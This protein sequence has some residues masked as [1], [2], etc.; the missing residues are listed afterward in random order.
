MSE[1]PMWEIFCTIERFRTDKKDPLFNI[2]CRIRATSMFY[3]GPNPEPAQWW[4][5]IDPPEDYDEEEGYSYTEQEVEII[6]ELVEILRKEHAWRGLEFEGWTEG[7]ENYHL[8]LPN[9]KCNLVS[10]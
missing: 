8:I 6:E 10:G 5:S 7:K 9:D 4:L 3:C 1:N 2:K